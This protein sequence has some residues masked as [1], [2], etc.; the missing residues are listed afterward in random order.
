MPARPTTSRSVPAASTSSVTVVAE[1]MIRAWAPTMAVEQL[2]GGQPEPHVDLV[3]GGAQA[4]E[5][6]VGDLFG[7]QDARH[8]TPCLPLAPTPTSTTEHGLQ[9]P[10]RT[11]C[12]R[13]SG[14][15]VAS[16][17]VRR[18]VAADDDARGDRAVVRRPRAAPLRRAPRLGDGRSGAGRCRC[19]SSPTCCS[20][21]TPST[22]RDWSVAENLPSPAFVARRR[23][24]SPGS[25]PT[26]CAAG[27]WFDRPHDIGP[28]ELAVFIVVP[29]I[30]SLRRRPVGRRR[31]RRSSMAVGLL[32]AAVGAHQ[33]RRA[34][35]A[36]AGP[37]SA[38]WPSSPLLL[39]VV[40]R[41][42]PLLLLFTT[43]LFINAE[44]WQVAGTLTGPVYVAVLGV[45]F[46][47]GA[48]VRAV[49]DAGADAARS[50]RSTRGPRSPSWPTTRPAAAVLDALAADRAGAAGRPP[51]VRQR[52]NIGLVTIFSQAIQITLVGARPD[53]R[54]SC[55]SG[56]SPSR[57]D[58]RAAWT[59]ARRRPRARRLARRRPRRSCSPS[60]CCASPAS[61]A[62]SR[63]CTSR[64][65]CRPTRTYREEFAEDVGAAVAP[66][67]RR[68][69]RRTEPRQGATDAS[70]GRVDR[71][72]ST[73]G[74]STTPAE[75]ATRWSHAVQPGVGH[76]RRRSSA[77]S[78]CGPSAT[79]AATSPRPTSTTRSSAAR[80][81]SSPATAA[82][83]RC[84]ATSPASCPASAAPGSAGR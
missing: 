44:V 37:G 79:P 10:T 71:A 42:L 38:P 32:A 14:R 34:A 76:D 54:S 64:S 22:S 17:T 72:T 39:N 77:S 67:S 50:T 25:S 43:F 52:V 73:S 83:R 59:G 80:S 19:S 63:A 69:L 41:A 58:T 81:A 65:C 9:R 20:A 8:R 74:C 26:G 70:D 4:V 57:E 11:P 62:R 21:S 16:S 7:D 27:R 55:C 12:R 53:R 75:H 61:S 68:A 33:L 66:S 5:P 30:P 48:I 35:A 84:T 29:A 60:R 46:L 31:C 45:F 82:H 13:H 51:A 49:A 24:S 6:A 78:C 1:R 3:A 40:A 18:C 28:A 15:G 56:S 2:V 36:R 23:S 47:L